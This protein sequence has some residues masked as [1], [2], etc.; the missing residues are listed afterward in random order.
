MQEGS[1]PSEAD[2]TIISLAYLYSKT[3]LRRPHAVN[4][5]AASHVCIALM[6][7][8]KKSYKALL[9]DKKRLGDLQAP[10]ASVSS[11]WYCA[12]RYFYCSYPH[13][14]MENV[15]RLNGSGT[16]VE[17]TSRV[18]GSSST[19][20][21]SRRFESESQ[22]HGLDGRGP[23]NVFPCS[24][25]SAAKTRVCRASLSPKNPRFES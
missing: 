7:V 4:F 3:H 22:G 17:V 25:C 9:E 15:F 8:P 23:R 1:V 12:P 20:D 14:L 11:C 16:L 6:R 18:R 5:G 19:E 21:Q 10:S 24:E 2:K 13:Q